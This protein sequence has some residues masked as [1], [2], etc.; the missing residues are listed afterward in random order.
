MFD[1]YQ[2][3]RVFTSF[4]T[5]SGVASLG[6]YWRCS[7]PSGPTRE[8]LDHVVNRAVGFD[9]ASDLESRHY[10][11]DVLHRPGQEQPAFALRVLCSRPIE[12]L[13]GPI[14][15]G[16]ER[17]RDELNVFAKLCSEMVRRSDQLG[18]H[19]LASP[20]TSRVDEIDQYPLAFETGKIDD[21]AVLIHEFHVRQAVGVAARTEDARREL[22]ALP[23]ASDHSQRY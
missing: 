10:L 9:G 19:Q 18:R 16:V 20:G 21:V 17:Y 1:S 4:A 5:A 6:L 3:A 13:L 23:L 22:R 7:R 14:M 2:D 12:Q 15:F 8:K 11:L